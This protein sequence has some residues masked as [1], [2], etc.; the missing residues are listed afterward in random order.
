MKQKQKDSLCEKASTVLM[1]FRVTVGI[2]HILQCSGNNS[3]L[4]TSNDVP[5]DVLE[6]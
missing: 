3:I 5:L 2:L 1:S 6:I 4:E